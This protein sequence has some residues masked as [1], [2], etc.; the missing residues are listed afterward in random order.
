MKTSL[1]KNNKN[2]FRYFLQ[3]ALE[4]GRAIKL[5]SDRLTQ[6]LLQEMRE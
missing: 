3:Q 2:D 6:Q 5:S 1:D 4:S